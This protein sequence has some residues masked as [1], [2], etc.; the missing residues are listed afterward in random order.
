MRAGVRCWSNGCSTAPAMPGP[1]AARR[2]PIPSR[3]APTP[4]AK[5]CAFSASSRRR[6]IAELSRILSI[7]T[8]PLAP[9]RLPV[10]RSPHAALEARAQHR[11]NRRRG[12]RGRVARRSRGRW[13]PRRCC[14]IP[15]CPGASRGAST[16]PRSCRPRNA[17]RS[18]PGFPSMRNSAS[19][20]PA[21]MRSSSFNILRAA[22]A[23]HAPRRR[24]ARPDA[25]AHHRRRQPRCRASPA[26]RDASSA[27]TASASPSPPPPSS[28]R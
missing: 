23:R 19:A 2:D 25:R 3:A 11:R 6:S 10:L 7:L 26:P 13:S 12:R 16:I 1:A 4:R 8:V 24:G 18:S 5:C 27:A 17:R 15:S 21:S 9:T 22:H 28:P 20:R 14:S